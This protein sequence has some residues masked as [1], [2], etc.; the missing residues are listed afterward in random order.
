[1]LFMV[2]LLSAAILATPAAAKYC[3][4]DPSCAAPNQLCCNESTSPP[5]GPTACG[6]ISAPNGTGLVGGC[7][8]VGG[9]PA[10]CIDGQ[11]TSGT[12]PA[13]A[14]DA[15]KACDCASCQAP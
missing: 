3:R 4:P 6:A 8:N 5:S 15:C 1:M 9:M 13:A 10:G 2:M 14:V 11:T 12:C 7:T